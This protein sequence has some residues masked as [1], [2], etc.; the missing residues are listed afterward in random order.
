[1]ELEFFLEKYLTITTLGWDGKRGTLKWVGA[2]RSDVVYSKGLASEEK[3]RVIRVNYRQLQEQLYLSPLSKRTQK[4]RGTLVGD[5]LPGISTTS[6]QV[7]HNWEKYINSLHQFQNHFRLD[8]RCMKVA[9][10]SLLKTYCIIVFILSNAFQTHWHVP[11]PW[12]E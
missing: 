7:G 1:M 8:P 10:R 3:I 4:W 9:V 12:R 6:R 5:R 11:N 2:Q